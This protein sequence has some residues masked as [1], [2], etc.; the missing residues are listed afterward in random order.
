MYSFISNPY[1]W[2]N[3]PLLD[4]VQVGPYPQ[5]LCSKCQTGIVV[6]SYSFLLLYTCACV[7]INGYEKYEQSIVKVHLDK[8]QK[9]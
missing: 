4:G 6:G 1:M 2:S 9:I 7:C 8:R 3:R 5:W